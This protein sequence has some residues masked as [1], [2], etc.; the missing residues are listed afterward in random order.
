MVIN[1]SLYEHYSR[2]WWF[3]YKVHEGGG[4]R[5]IKFEIK[6]LVNFNKTFGE[7]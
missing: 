7:L 4:V 2:L 5:S 3:A 1:L 6:Q